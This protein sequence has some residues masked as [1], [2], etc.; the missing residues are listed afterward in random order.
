[1][2]ATATE[3]L[4][5]AQP[6]AR[7]ALSEALNDPDALVRAYAVLALAELPPAERPPLLVPRLRDPIRLVRINAAQALA[8][9][10]PG[11]LAGADQATFN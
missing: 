1:V 11:T 8:A 7:I 5:P 4:P 6:E 10:P 9:L 2:R 3:H